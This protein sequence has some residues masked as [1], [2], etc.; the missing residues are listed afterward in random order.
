MG[1]SLLWRTILSDKSRWILKLEHY[2]FSIYN[3]IK[4][5]GNDHQWLIIWQKDKE[6]LCTFLWKYAPPLR[7]YTCQ[8]YWK[9][10]DQ[11]SGY[12]ITWHTGKESHAK[13]TGVMQLANPII[14]NMIQEKNNI[15]LQQQ[16]NSE[17]LKRW[18]GKLCTKSHFN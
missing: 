1:M 9:E 15:N 8:K 16:Q 4:D 2:Y 13:D 18:S 14:L 11:S 12:Q 7:K 3:E 6:A 17:T 10:Y 5:V